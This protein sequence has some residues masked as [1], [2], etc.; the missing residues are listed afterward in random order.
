MQIFQPH[1][2]T[3]TH[4]PN[5]KWKFRGSLKQEDIKIISIGVANEPEQQKVGFTHAWWS[6]IPIKT[7]KK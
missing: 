1:W 5:I 6:I 2:R 7:A 3:L 4:K